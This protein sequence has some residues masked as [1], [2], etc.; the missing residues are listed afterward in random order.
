MNAAVTDLDCGEVK[1]ALKERDLSRDGGDGEESIIQRS[2][3]K[4]RHSG[5]SFHMF[6][7]PR[8]G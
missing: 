4:R 7:E 6:R 3:R 1:T 2:E 8:E 5:N